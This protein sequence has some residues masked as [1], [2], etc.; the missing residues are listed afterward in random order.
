MNPGAE[1]TVSICPG[2]PLT[3]SR[4][5]RSG[6]NSISRSPAVA[7]P[8]F[9]SVTWPTPSFARP[10]MGLELPGPAVAAA[11]AISSFR[12]PTP[13][14]SKSTRQ[15]V[16]PVRETL[17][18]PIGEKTLQPDKY[19]SIMS[20]HRRLPHHHANPPGACLYPQRFTNLPPTIPLRSLHAAD[21]S[22]NSQRKNAAG[23]SPRTRLFSPSSGQIR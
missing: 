20:F 15:L 1:W 19:P 14:L 11:T 2:R 6:Q 13:L 3:R 18:P 22:R 21:A 7:K 23:A 5:R 4:R 8:A 16:E 17:R 10:S 9:G 12:L